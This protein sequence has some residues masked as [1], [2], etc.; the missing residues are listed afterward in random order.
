MVYQLTGQRTH[1]NG[2]TPKRLRGLW[3]ITRSVKNPIAFFNFN[4]DEKK[5]AK[6]LEFFSELQVKPRLRMTPVKKRWNA[7]NS[8]TRKTQNY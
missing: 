7:K 6:L 3:G 5:K 8:I 1:T 2:K 4:K